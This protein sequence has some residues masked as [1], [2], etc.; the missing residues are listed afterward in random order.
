MTKTITKEIIEGNPAGRIYHETK[1]PR[2]LSKYSPILNHRMPDIKPSEIAQIII[3][4][5]ARVFFI[6]QSF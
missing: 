4:I 5:N 2:K 1:L 6:K 3:D